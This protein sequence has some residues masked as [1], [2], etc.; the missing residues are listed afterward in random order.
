MEKIIEIY[1]DV[2]NGAWCKK[3]GRIYP[4]HMPHAHAPCP[5]LV[6]QYVSLLK[7]SIILNSIRNG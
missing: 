6:F 4:C 7:E 3:H 5:K 1:F 2:L